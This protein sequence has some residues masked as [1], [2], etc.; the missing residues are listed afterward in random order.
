MP[1]DRDAARFVEKISRQHGS[2]VPGIG[3]EAEFATLS[4]KLTDGTERLLYAQRLFN[5][6][7]PDMPI[8]E[9]QDFIEEKVS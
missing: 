6:D 8:K 9:I 2:V 1:E 4:L 5:N 3:D 7:V